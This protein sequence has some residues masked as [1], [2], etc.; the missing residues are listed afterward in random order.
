MAPVE[1]TA[2]HGDRPRSGRSI[3]F[4][5]APPVLLLSPDFPISSWHPAPQNT[6]PPNTPSPF[7]TQSEALKLPCSTASATFVMVLS[8][9]ALNPNRQCATPLRPFLNGSHSVVIGWAR[10]RFDRRAI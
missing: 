2:Q 8:E 7:R 6:P 5:E 1:Q 3:Q 10:R 9:T 4:L